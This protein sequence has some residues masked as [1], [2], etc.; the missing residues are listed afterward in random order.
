MNRLP[1][2]VLFYRLGFYTKNLIDIK[3]FVWG[4]IFSSTY[5]Y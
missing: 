5:E 3:R 1:D 4:A 2:H